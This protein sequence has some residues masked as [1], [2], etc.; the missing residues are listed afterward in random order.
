MSDAGSAPW[1][2]THREVGSRLEELR[3][4]RDLTQRAAVDL[5][6]QEH[7]VKTNIST[8]SNIEN[9]KRKRLPSELVEALLDVY[10]AEPQARQHVLDLL[11][12]DTTPAGRP[13]RPASWR[14]NST[15]LGPTQFEGFLRMERRASSI[16]NY[17]RDLLPGLF[18]TEEYANAVITGMRPDL[19]PREVKVL[20]DVRMERQR[21]VDEWAMASFRALINLEAVNDAACDL[22]QIRRLL[23]E[24]EKPKQEIRLLPKI[25]FHPGM[26]GPFVVMHFPEAA[27]EVA[28]AET[29]THS[30]YVDTEASVRLYTDAFT[31]MWQRA[32][33]PDET[34]IRLENKIKELQK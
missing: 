15:L 6:L 32:L 22:I 10:G 28:W 33:K 8:L 30:V 27:R 12:V 23:Q 24:C 29:M 25:G 26:A 9:G 16:D 17:E 5:L 14:R 31:G 1:S 13:R 20:V 19:S 11:S 21:Q 7:G 18:Q 34:Y 4:R 3:E 2:L